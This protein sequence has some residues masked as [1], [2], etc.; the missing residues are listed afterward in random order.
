MAQVCQWFARLKCNSPSEL[1]LWRLGMVFWGVMLSASTYAQEALSQ[2]EL[3]ERLAPYYA[4]SAEFVGDL[5]N[6]QS[7]L[8]LDSG[9]RVSSAK[10]W[11]KRRAEDSQDL[12]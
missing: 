4:P 2:V 1:S 9:Q 3:G 6:Y 11:Q 12:A 5:G 7:P 10:Q 8:T